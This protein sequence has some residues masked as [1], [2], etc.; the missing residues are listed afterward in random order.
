[1]LSQLLAA[2]Q[3]SKHERAMRHG[4]QHIQAECDATVGTLPSTPHFM[5]GPV[6]RPGVGDCRQRTAG[7]PKIWGHMCS[8]TRP[9]VVQS[10][11]VATI[12]S[13]KCT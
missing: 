6:R 11:S 10:I 12:Q 1:M 13:R 2:Q 5:H 4:G 8:N 9:L 7:S 3:D